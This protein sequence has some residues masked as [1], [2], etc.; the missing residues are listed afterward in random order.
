M[1]RFTFAHE[2]FARVLALVVQ[3]IGWRSHYPFAASASANPEYRGV[4]REYLL[5]F[6]A[7]S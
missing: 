7:T 1:R 4:Q 3:A 5:I 6:P 2:R